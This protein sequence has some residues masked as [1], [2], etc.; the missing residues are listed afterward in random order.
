MRTYRAALAPGGIIA[1][2]V[3]NHFLDLRPVVTGLASD[4]GLSAAEVDGLGDAIAHTN[5][6][7]WMLVAEDRALLEGANLSRSA[8]APMPSPVLWTDDYSS[9]W[10]VLK[11]GF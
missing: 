4:A 1:V 5:A 11:S 7:V 10:K 6:S 9:L 2:H 3:S 8:A